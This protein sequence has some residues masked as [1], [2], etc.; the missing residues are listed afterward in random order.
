[1][2]ASV[3]AVAVAICTLF[4]MMSL[5][6][7]SPARSPR[8][9]FSFTAKNCTEAA[10]LFFFDPAVLRPYV[11]EEFE[12]GIVSAG[13][14]ELL[15]LTTSC[16]AGGSQK[17]AAPLVL[18]EVGIY[19]QDV[20]ASPGNWHYYGLWHVSSSK[21]LSRSLARLGVAGSHV[22]DATFSSR[23]GSMDFSASIPWE[24]APY[25]VEMVAAPIGS[26]FGTRPSV[27]WYPDGKGDYVRV[28]YGIEEE[29]AIRSG[30]GT[31]EVSPGSTFAEIFGGTSRPSDSVMVA[32]YAK[33]TAEIS[34][35]ELR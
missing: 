11:P 34:R 21:Q 3:R 31:I 4:L 24:T 14:A 12:L 25:S 33:L 29:T 6:G 13:R 20:D 5:A 18:S 35:I 22:P 30:A 27:W 17:S 28:I 8:K 9:T 7:T 19:I 2:V 15:V 26:L 23:T 32:D 16:D 1:M 10:S